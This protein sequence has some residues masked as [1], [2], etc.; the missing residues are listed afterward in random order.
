MIKKT[1]LSKLT[2]Q[3][4]PSMLSV[5]DT[6]GGCGSFFDIRVKSDKFNTIPTLKQHQL[7]K[8][9]INDEIKQ[10]HGIQLTTMKDLIK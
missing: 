4:K 9:I 1:I 6:S 8:G 3:L 2:A 10:V 5:E 7:V